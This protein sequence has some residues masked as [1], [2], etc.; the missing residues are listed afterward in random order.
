MKKLFLL[1]SISL[2]SF[3]DAFAC[4]CAIY[5]SL[6]TFIGERYKASDFVISAKIEFV[7]DSLTK[8]NY[9]MSSDSNYWRQGG[10]NAV[11][12]ISKVYKGELKADTIEITPNWSNCSQYFKT[13]D[14]YIIFGYIN[15]KGEFTTS[16]CSGNFS[17]VKKDWWKVFQKIN[18]E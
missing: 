7:K 14:T 11:L 12:K 18:K 9:I 15:K 17:T 4:K 1:I 5:S 3:T 6:E 2:V 16:V 8:G 10:Y 13:G